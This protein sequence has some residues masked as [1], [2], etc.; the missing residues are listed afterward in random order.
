MIGPPRRLEQR[1]GAPPT[2]VQLA[3]ALQVSLN[4]YHEIMRDAQG[5]QLIYYEDFQKDSDDHFLD[6]NCADPRKHPLDA[7]LDE[8]LRASVVKAIDDLPEREKM[9]MGMHY[10]Q[11]LNLR[12]IGAVLGMSPSGVRSRLSRLLERLRTEVGND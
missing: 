6:R 7:L 4:E 1:L 2:E 12:E 10:E 5:A 3:Q 9:E 8:D 11:G